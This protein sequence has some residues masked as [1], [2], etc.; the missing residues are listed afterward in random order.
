MNLTSYYPLFE[1]FYTIL[2]LRIQIVLIVSRSCGSYPGR[3]CRI[4][5]VLVVSGSCMV[6]SR[7]IRVVLVVS[8]F[9]TVPS[10]ILFRRSVR[11]I[12]TSYGS[13]LF[14]SDTLLMYFDNPP[15]L[16]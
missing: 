15:Y 7:R 4:R 8:G 1:A 9:K 12:V 5:I 2:K 13:R 6:V 3:A 14:W 16:D 10:R 11:N